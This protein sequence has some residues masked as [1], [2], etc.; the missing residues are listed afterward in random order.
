MPTIAIPTASR[1]NLI[2]EGMCVESIT[3]SNWLK[4]STWEKNRQGSLAIRGQSLEWCQTECDGMSDCRFISYWNE[5]HNPSC[6]FWSGINCDGPRFA[7][8]DRY[9]SYQKVIG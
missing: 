4:H 8:D 3:D 2:G 1:Y 6:F 5:T 7:K 9:K